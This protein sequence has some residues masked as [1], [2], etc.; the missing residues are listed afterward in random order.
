[1]KT[2]S[3]NYSKYSKVIPYFFWAI[4]VEFSYQQQHHYNLFYSNF[5]WGKDYICGKFL[6][7]ELQNK[8]YSGFVFR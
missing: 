8:K 6:E 2:G 4:F 5:N 3:L 7:A 1:M